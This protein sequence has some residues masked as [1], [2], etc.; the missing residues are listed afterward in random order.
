MK[1]YAVIPNTF[2]L[3][4]NGYY[5][6]QITDSEVDGQ[7]VENSREEVFA[8]GPGAL[9]SFSQNNH[10]FFNA[11]FETAAE[12]RSEGQRYLLRYVHHF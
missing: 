12:N 10:L 1:H 4:I 2:R 8:V 11:Y 7:D 5:L 3:G 9:W 6:K